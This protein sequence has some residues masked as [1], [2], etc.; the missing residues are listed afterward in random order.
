M[1]L[2]ARRSGTW[3]ETDEAA[4][5]TRM[6]RNIAATLA[7]VGAPARRI[8]PST[9]RG[10]GRLLS[11]SEPPGIRSMPSIDGRE[12][13]RYTALALLVMRRSLERPSTPWM[14]YRRAVE[15]Y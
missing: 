12:H 14:L 4:A 3:I 5:V 11:P 6:E 2:V 13:T 10:N 7:R 8:N 9:R 1:E 15:R